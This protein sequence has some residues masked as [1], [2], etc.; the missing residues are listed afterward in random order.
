MHSSGGSNRMQQAERQP[1]QQGVSSV[2]S[3]LPG[4]VIKQASGSMSQMLG[5][6]AEAQVAD[7]TQHRMQQLHVT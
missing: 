2:K 5:A 4:E 1:R 6:Q 7:C 3:K